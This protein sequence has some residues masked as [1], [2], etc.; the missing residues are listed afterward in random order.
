MSERPT[1]E[2]R[3][4]TFE[5]VAIVRPHLRDPIKK[6]LTK[7]NI[8]GMTATQVEGYGRQLGHSEHYRGAEY[9][10]EFLPKLQLTILVAA[11]DLDA[12]LTAIKDAARKEMIPDLGR[13][14][15]GTGIAYIRPVEEAIRLSNFTKLCE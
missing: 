15:Y 11:K 6:E 10:I 12:A 14:P 1:D 9:E 3:S 13:A 8:L 5:V 2:S 4:G 7:A